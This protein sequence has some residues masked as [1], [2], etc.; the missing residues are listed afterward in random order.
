[1]SEQGFAPPRVTVIVPVY[2]DTHGLES[3]V[4]TLLDVDYPPELIEIVVVDNHPDPV[5]PQELFGAVVVHEPSAGSYAARNAGTAV[6]T[7]E[8]LAF[9]D[10]DCRPT[11]GWLREGVAALMRS[12]H[13]LVGGNIAVVCE[14][15]PTVAAELELRYSLPQDRY[16][17]EG[18][19]ATANLFV[20]REDLMALG[21]F[22]ARLRSGGDRDLGYRATAAGF[23]YRFAAEAIVE[24]H[25]RTEL[26][27]VLK[28][29]R[30]VTAGALIVVRKHQGRPG[31]LRH[32]LR[33]AKPPLRRISA[34]L[35]EADL[36]P[37]R[38]VALAAA[39]AL[40]YVVGL[41]AAIRQVLPRSPIP[42]RT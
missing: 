16:V 31:V 25:A 34:L 24:H 32:L 33:M 7:G 41:W 2:G 35:G 13:C 9:T 18:Y 5:V 6:A 19:A 10:A 27:S 12:T 39:S 15:M 3:L 30:R 4:T 40:V 28:K 29:T 1:M 17:R 14:G 42:P 22:D 11:R 38:R 37:R 26:R 23:H 20:R 36:D 8:I 21:G